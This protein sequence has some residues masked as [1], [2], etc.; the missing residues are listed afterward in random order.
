M[1]AIVESG[2]KQYRVA[3]GD[4]LVVDHVVGSEEGAEHTLPVLLLGGDV[5]KVG[6][7]TVEGASVT[8][9]VVEHFLGEKIVTFKYKRRQRSRVKTGYRHTHTALEITAING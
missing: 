3:V 6:S 4:T 8:A 2:S 1:Y 7:P 9:K 5:V